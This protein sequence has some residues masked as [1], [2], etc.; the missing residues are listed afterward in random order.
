MSKNKNENIF[1]SDANR[2]LKVQDTQ[3]HQCVAHQ[4]LIMHVVWKQTYQLQVKHAHLED[5]SP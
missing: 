2:L 5:F 1:K 3:N 4:V